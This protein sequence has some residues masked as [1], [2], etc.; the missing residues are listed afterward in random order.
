MSDGAREHAVTAGKSI[1]S[2]SSASSAG[3]ANYTSTSTTSATTPARFPSR[4]V[5]PLPF[6]RKLRYHMDSCAGTNKSQFCFGGLGL[7]CAAGILDAVNVS[8]MVV[9]HT[10]FDPDLVANKIAQQYNKEDSFNQAAFLQHKRDVSS[11]QAYDDELLE[12][13]KGGQRRC[14]ELWT[15]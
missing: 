2:I 13:W 6:V 14:S 4:D 5:V 10:K 8:F 12:T 7:L 9:G 3:A 11:A 15:T 1:T